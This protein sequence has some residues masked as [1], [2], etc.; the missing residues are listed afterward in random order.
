MNKIN[1]LKIARIAAKIADDKKC[2]DILILNVKRLTII[3][4][5]FLIATAESSPQMNAVLD[6]VFKTLKEKE[7]LFP[8]H[9]EGR[10]S[11]S[12]AVLDYGGLVIHIMSQPA[13]NLY[14]LEKLWSDARKVK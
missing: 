4:D 12:W 14:S 10:Q 13:R 6:A 3:A 7:N 1:F 5:Y 11:S 8:I 2:N 9:R